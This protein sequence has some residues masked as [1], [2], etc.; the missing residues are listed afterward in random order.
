MPLTSALSSPGRRRAPCCAPARAAKV[1]PTI[2]D[3]MRT[4][5]PPGGSLRGRSAARSCA[6]HV[7]ALGRSHRVG[8]AEGSPRNPSLPPQVPTTAEI[9][10][11]AVTAT[12]LRFSA[13]LDVRGPPSQPFSH[14]R[15]A[16]SP[17]TSPSLA[18][19]SP[20][21]VACPLP[22]PA[23]GLTQHASPLLWQV[24]CRR[25]LHRRRHHRLSERAAA[26]RCEQPMRAE[27]THGRA[28]ARDWRRTRLSCGLPRGRARCARAGT[29]ALPAQE[30]RSLHTRHLHTLFTL[31]LSP[32]HHSLS[33]RSPTLGRPPLEMT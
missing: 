13:S 12:F 30:V 33:S 5:A 2:L 17:L 28:D 19:T 29:R 14:P 11:S 8:A 15:H 1:P 24:L 27:S 16:S 25:E 18:R 22:A 7:D 26:G 31:S 3:E 23:R 32:S 9:D 20:R 4:C 10:F 6:H 21:A